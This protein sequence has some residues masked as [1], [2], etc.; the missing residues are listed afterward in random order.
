MVASR[1]RP[2][3]EVLMSATGSVFEKDLLPEQ[4]LVPNC[5]CCGPENS[6]GLHLRFTRENPTTV[7]TEFTPPE[8]WTGWGRIMHG[9]FHGLL[10]DETM[11]WVVFGLLGLQAFVTQEISVRYHRPVYVGQPLRIEASL[12]EDSGRAIRVRGEIRDGNG[13][14]L[15]SASCTIIRLEAERMESIL[16][17]TK[18]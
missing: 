7:S 5:Y 12:V 18:A 11:G 8:Y 16:S 9:G 17:N 10:L 3:G 15:T 4:D 1:D 14:V 6:E 2:S 13:A